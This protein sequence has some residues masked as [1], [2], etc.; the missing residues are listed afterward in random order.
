MTELK[1]TPSIAVGRLSI[2]DVL[3]RYSTT[4]VLYVAIVFMYYDIMLGHH[5]DTHGSVQ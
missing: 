4:S 3:V 1:T 2:A 5:H